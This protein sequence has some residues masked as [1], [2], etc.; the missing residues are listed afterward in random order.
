[1]LTGTLLKPGRDFG[2]VLGSPRESSLPSYALRYP[3]SQSGQ[4]VE[5]G[6]QICRSTFTSATAWK[7]FM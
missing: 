7:C 5:L 2:P 6:Q 4:A 3:R 1:M